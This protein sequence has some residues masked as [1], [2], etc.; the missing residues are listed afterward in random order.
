MAFEFALKQ[1]ST[2]VYADVHPYIL[3]LHD[4]MMVLVEFGIN[5]IDM[6][7]AALLHDIIEDTPANYHDVNNEFGKDVAEIVYALTDE[8]GKNRK[9]RKR[10]TLPKLDHKIQ[11][12]AI[13]V[14]DWISNVRQCYRNS[15]KMYQMYKKDFPEFHKFKEQVQEFPLIEKELIAMWEELERLLSKSEK[16]FMEGLNTHHPEFDDA[17]IS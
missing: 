15:H 1:H 2:Q 4:V 12:Q 10:K 17:S 6:L 5:N 8:L 16:E 9:E 11:A 7:T 13:K 3:H 14:A